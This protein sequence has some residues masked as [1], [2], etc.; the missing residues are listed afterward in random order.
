MD[1]VEA[2]TNKHFATYVAQKLPH[3]G[4]EFQSILAYSTKTVP[5]NVANVLQDIQSDMVGI[6]Y[7]RYGPTRMTL[8]EKRTDVGNLTGASYELTRAET[9]TDQIGAMADFTEGFASAVEEILVVKA[10]IRLVIA[11]AEA[12][13]FPQPT[14]D[15]LRKL[16]DNASTTGLQVRFDKF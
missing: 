10:T 11:F 14:I 16:L 1:D 15:Y 3:S 13:K 8:A 2:L 9:L 4:E 6:V 7:D 5:E 12:L